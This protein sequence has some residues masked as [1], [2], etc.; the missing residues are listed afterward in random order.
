MTNRGELFARWRHDQAGYRTTEANRALLAQKHFTAI[1]G[2]AGVGKSTTMQRASEID[3]RF[4]VVGTLTSRPQR[5]SDNPSLY[6]Y[7][8]SDRELHT[9]E[10]AIV[11]KE[12]VQYAVDPTN[13]VIYGS[14]AADYP[15][16]YNL[17]DVWASALPD[18]EKLGFKTF[19]V[20]ALVAD[21]A[22]WEKWFRQRFEPGDEVARKRIH[23]AQ[24]ALPS[25][26]DSPFDITWL[27]NRHGA[28]D[29]TAQGVIN[30][31]LG[32]TSTID[33][34]AIAKAMLDTAKRLEKEF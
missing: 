10:Q 11:E 34:P 24:L 20:I 19:T 7:I 26:I 16:T 8:T 21:P 4:A 28:I 25:L 13:D 18:F 32:G 3:D 31:S 23:E 29:D 2:P 14:T 33:G 12:L 6:T 27:L 30:I 22:D 9:L 17:G 15:N 1:V 5:E